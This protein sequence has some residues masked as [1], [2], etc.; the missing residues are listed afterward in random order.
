M[1]KNSIAAKDPWVPEILL[2]ILGES[3]AHL[4]QGPTVGTEQCLAVAAF[5]TFCPQRGWELHALVSGHNHFVWGNDLWRSLVTRNWINCSR[6]TLWMTAVWGF[7]CS[8]QLWKHHSTG[9]HWSAELKKFRHPVLLEDKGCYAGCLKRLRSCGLWN[10][11]LGK[12]AQVWIGRGLAV[13][14]QKQF[15]AM[16]FQDLLKM[17]C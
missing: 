8:S 16:L 12:A 11:V 6:I 5:N 4:M 7:Q 2:Q 1:S 15:G 17:L 13:S 10:E 3:M 14:S 9:G